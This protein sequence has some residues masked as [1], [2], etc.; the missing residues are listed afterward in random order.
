[1]MMPNY[2]VRDSLSRP[3]HL[4]MTALVKFLEKIE[5]K[6]RLY[7]HKTIVALKPLLIILYN[8]VPLPFAEY[9]TTHKAR[10]M[11]THLAN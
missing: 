7:K 3:K 1:M 5:K 2:V 4:N 11:V 9:K 10:N 6:T 8:F